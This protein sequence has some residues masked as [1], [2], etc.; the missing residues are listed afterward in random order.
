MN[1]KETIKDYLEEYENM[2]ELQCNHCGTIFKGDHECDYD[3]IKM[4]NKRYREGI[5]KLKDYLE[6][7]IP[8]VPDNE[9]PLILTE[10]LKII[11]EIFEGD[12]H[13]SS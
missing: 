10:S 7:T 2:P 5:K 13:E 6:G 9:K 11:D 12:S 4:Q 8:S 3:K 1:E